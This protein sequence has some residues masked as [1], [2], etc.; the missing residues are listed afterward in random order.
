MKQ[1]HSTL[2]GFDEEPGRMKGNTTRQADRAIQILFNEGVVKVE[3]HCQ[4]GDHKAS[5]E[6][7]FDRITSRLKAEHRIDFRVDKENLIISLGYYERR[8][9]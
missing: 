2:Q 9:I 4:E 7:L 5:N 8:T 6:D 3:D 1:I